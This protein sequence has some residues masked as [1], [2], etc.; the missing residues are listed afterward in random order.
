MNIKKQKRLVGRMLDVGY[1]RVWFDPS[2][3]DEI[4]EAIT[5]ADLRSLINDKAIQ[6][7]HKKG[8][9]RVRVRKTLKQKRKGR[10]QG[11]GSKKGKK[12]ARLRRKETWVNNVRLQRVFVKTLKDSKYV[13][14][15]GYRELR[16]KIKGGFFRSKKHIKIYLESKGILKKDGKK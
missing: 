5:K 1:E 4:K 12:G 6:I 16:N 10:R 13:D 14:S 7:K 3:L 15:K 9:S 2:R 8:I 11:A